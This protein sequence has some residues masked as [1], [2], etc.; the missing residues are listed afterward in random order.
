[1]AKLPN[2]EQLAAWTYDITHH[3]FV[4]EN[5]KT[6]MQAFATTRIPWE[7][8]SALSLHFQRFIPTRTRSVTPTIGWRKST[9]H[10]EGAD[11][12]RVHLSPQSRLAL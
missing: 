8:S 10:R 6:L 7:C 2:Q 4:H 3:T 9:T 5:I 12:R 11:N 1:L